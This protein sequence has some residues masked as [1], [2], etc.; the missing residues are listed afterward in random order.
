LEAFGIKEFV[1]LQILVLPLLLIGCFVLYILSQK[2]FRVQTHFLV[3]LVYFFSEILCSV[4][5]HG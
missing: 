2:K 4:L 3:L 5:I 1:L